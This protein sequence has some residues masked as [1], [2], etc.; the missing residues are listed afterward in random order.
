MMQENLSSGVCEQQ[1]QRPACAPVQSDQCLCYSLIDLF[2]MLLYIP[3]NSFGHGG[4][5][6]SPNHTFS[7]TSLNKQ[8]PVI[9]AHT[10][11][12]N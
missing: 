9:C 6:S 1:R 7:W 3:I 11:T 8:V 4:M 12:C 2:V 10:F 5:V